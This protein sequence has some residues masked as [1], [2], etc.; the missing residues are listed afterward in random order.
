MLREPTPDSETL[1]AGVGLAALGGGT[2]VHIWL[3][4]IRDLAESRSVLIKLT[5]SGVETLGSREACRVR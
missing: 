2:G 4:R 1:C 3:R 5:S